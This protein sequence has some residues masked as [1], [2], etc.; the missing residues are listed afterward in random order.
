MTRLERFISLLLLAF[1][2]LYLAESLTLGFGNSKLPG[3]GLVPTIVGIFLIFLVS[4]HL[5]TDFLNRRP[6]EQKNKEW[7]LLHG[8]DSVRI[9]EMLLLLVFCG[10][11]IGKLGYIIT[12]IILVGASLYFLEMRGWVKIT[13]ISILTS[14]ISYYFFGVMFDIPLPQGILPF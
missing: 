2:G 13:L 8:K 9:V 12:T 10:V 6:L 1:S 11:F 4:L 5:V 7:P 14:G 3:P